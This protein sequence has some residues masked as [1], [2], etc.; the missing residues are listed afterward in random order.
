[1]SFVTGYFGLDFDIDLKI[2]LV[3]LTRISG[4]I[5]TI[6]NCLRDLY[7]ETINFDFAEL[8]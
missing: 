8:R 3:F 4:C 7:G 6:F 5:G 1:M 2:S